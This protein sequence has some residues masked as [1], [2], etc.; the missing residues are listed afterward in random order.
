MNHLERKVRKVNEKETEITKMYD[1]KTGG[2][3]AYN[4]QIKSLVEGWDQRILK[5]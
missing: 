5:K 3:K 1:K 2:Y 4:C